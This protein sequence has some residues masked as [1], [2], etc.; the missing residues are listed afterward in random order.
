MF[1]V[2]A[3]RQRV[4]AS[5]EVSLEPGLKVLGTRYAR[6]LDTSV[7]LDVIFQDGSGD[8]HLVRVDLTAFSESSGGVTDVERLAQE[9]VTS[10][11]NVGSNV[12]VGVQRTTLHHWS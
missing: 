10:V 12:S 9:V 11:E 8:L 6:L 4:E 2:E 3:V 5:L 1:D 7:V